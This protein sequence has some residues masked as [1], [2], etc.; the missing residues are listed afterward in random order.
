MDL[1]KEF[2]EIYE[3]VIFGN[4][5]SIDNDDLEKE[6]GKLQNTIGNLMRGD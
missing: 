1:K 6:K 2:F 3:L 4:A 5:I